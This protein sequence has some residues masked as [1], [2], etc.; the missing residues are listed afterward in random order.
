VPRTLPH[1]GIAGHLNRDDEKLFKQMVS[2]IKGFPNEPS[3]GPSRQRDEGNVEGKKKNH[4][5]SVSRNTTESA[6][7]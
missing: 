1:R 4:L 3:Y 5:P 7:A 6:G 2:A